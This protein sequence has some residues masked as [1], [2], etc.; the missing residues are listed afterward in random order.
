MGI[1]LMEKR[2]AYSPMM[3]KTSNQIQRKKDNTSESR[4]N[5]QC[6]KC[7][8]IYE[9]EFQIKRHAWRYHEKVN[10]RLCGQASLS[11]QDLE[12]HKRVDHGITKNIECSFCANINCVDGSE[13]LFSHETQNHNTGNVPQIRSETINQ[14]YC[15]KGLQC[16]RECGISNEGHKKVKEIPCKFGQ[17]CNR[18]NCYFKHKPDQ[19]AGFQESQRDRKN[20]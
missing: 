10:C 4:S 8:K 5:I 13:C 12:N 17:T 18:K 11:R 16:T 19:R 15:T 9:T 20:P 7:P 1:A 14:K 3:S 2:S 6:E